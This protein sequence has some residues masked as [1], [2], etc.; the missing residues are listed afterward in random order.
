[1]A[2]TVQCESQ[3]ETSGRPVSLTRYRGRADVPAIETL[4]RPELKAGLSRKERPHQ[5][6]EAQERRARENALVAGA[7]RALER[8][9]VMLEPC[10]GRKAGYEREDCGS[11]P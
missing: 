10:S 1:M 9:P 4:Q 7:E 11:T 2:R 5:G 6:S 8:T 3:P